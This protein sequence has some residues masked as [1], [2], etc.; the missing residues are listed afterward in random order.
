MEDIKRKLQ[1]YLNQ[2][3][4]YDKEEELE[5]YQLTI[6]KDLFRFSKNKID[7]EILLFLLYN[8]Q[9]NNSFKE[10]LAIINDLLKTNIFQKNGVLFLGIIDLRIVK[11]F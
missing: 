9:N 2:E 6:K 5:L 8:C 10:N 4:Q 1:E 3:A 7:F 11:C